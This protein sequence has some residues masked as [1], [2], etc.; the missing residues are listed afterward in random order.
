MGAG[1]PPRVKHC[2]RLRLSGDKI[3]P[4][5]KTFRAFVA[6]PS[7]FLIA[8]RRTGTPP[9][10]TGLQ[11]FFVGRLGNMQTAAEILTV[12]LIFATGFLLLAL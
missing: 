11:P 4:A 1:I 12:L 3:R 10:A 7:L 6:R 5:K 2:E 9:N 8:P